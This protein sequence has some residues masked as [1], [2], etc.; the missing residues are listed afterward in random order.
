MKVVMLTR[1]R[2]HV[3]YIFDK[4]TIYKIEGNQIFCNGGELV[5]DR[6]IVL[7]DEVEVKRDDEVTEALLALDKTENFIFKEVTVQE[8]VK[9]LELK[10]QQLEKEKQ[11]LENRTQSLEMTMLD[12]MDMYTQSLKNGIDLS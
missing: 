1:E 6:F 7:E 12:I 5:V 3:E 2:T 8:Q 10:N 9:E 11:L 4:L